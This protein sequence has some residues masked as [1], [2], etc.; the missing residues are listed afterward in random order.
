MSGAESES[1]PCPRH[2]A[3]AYDNNTQTTWRFCKDWQHA[4]VCFKRSW[5]PS[6]SNRVPHSRRKRSW[7]SVGLKLKGHC[8]C[9]SCARFWQ[10]GHCNNLIFRV[11]DTF[12]FWTPR[13]GPPQLRWKLAASMQTKILMWSNCI[14]QKGSCFQQLAKFHN[15]KKGVATHYHFSLQTKPFPGCFQ[16]PF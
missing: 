8:S 16:F 14:M 7:L 13:S 3:K 6:I 5:G 2:A 9:Y 1:A 10:N 4:L 15:A 12:A 11:V